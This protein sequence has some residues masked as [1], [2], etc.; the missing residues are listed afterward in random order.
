MPIKILTK[1]GLW[2]TLLLLVLVLLVA[3]CR[4]EKVTPIV[5]SDRQNIENAT[6]TAYALTNAP[7]TAGPSPTPTITPTPYQTPTPFPEADPEAIVATVGNREITLAEFQARVRYERWLPFYAIVRNMADANYD[8]LDL[9]LPQNSETLALIYTVN[10]D[11][12]SFAS[13]VLNVMITEQIVLQEAAKMDLE[14]EQTIF[15]GR[16]A[17]RI[18]ITLGEGGARPD[19]WDEAYETFLTDM[20]LYSAMSEAQ[21]LEH[22]RALAYYQQMSEII[23]AQA[24][25]PRD[26][27]ISQATV[28]DIIMDTRDD[29]LDV[30]DRLGEGEQLFA[31]AR[32]Y[33]KLP[34]E[35][36]TERDITRGTEG[37][38]D[39]IKTAIFDAEEGDIIGPFPTSEG[40][41]LALV[42]SFVVDIPQPADLQA[43]REEHYRQW[44]LERMD[45]PEY[46]IN[47]DNWLS[48]VPKDPLPRD[49]SPLLSDDNFV[50]PDSPFEEIDGA[51]PTPIPLGNSPR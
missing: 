38:P 17:A 27:I 10:G 19:S 49:I 32:E 25:L 22:I 42:V 14:M 40:W 23:G 3:A 39:A 43:V 45:D 29:A 15:D 1:R 33:G 8:L 30:I 21:F 5:Q 26:Q 20:Q 18:G 47:H 51:T 37:L 16:L 48:F 7:P 34:T 50:L 41:Y 35:G 28:Q 46:T 4:D 11:P 36:S 2:L 24:E 12:N 6:G 13:Q 9:S 44:I 31:L